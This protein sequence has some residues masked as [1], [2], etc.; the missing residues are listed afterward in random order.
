MK[1]RVSKMIGDV[2]VAMDMNSRDTHLQLSGDSDTLELNELIRSI[3]TDAVREVECAAPVY[4][5]ESGHNFGEE[6][7]LKSD[8]RGHVNLPDDFMRL[9]CFQMNDWERCLY[10]AMSSEDVGYGRMQSRY[11]GLRGTPRTPRCAIVMRSE[12]K[13]LEFAGSRDDQAYVVQSSYQPYPEID[14]NDSIDVA[15]K[16]YR[17]SVLRAA[18]MVLGILGDERSSIL[19]DQCGKL[20]Q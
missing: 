4:M 8:G 5:L 1:V 16:C 14:R 15:E 17:P 12:G 11:R 9:L 20:L 2:R 6:V 18:S 3:L 10:Q 19:N 7:H 13:V